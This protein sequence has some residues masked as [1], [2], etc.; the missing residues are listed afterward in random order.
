MLKGVAA[1]PGIAIGKVFLY[2]KEKAEI[3]M[4]NIDESKV[5]YEIERFKK[6]LEVT[7][8]QIQKIKE[9]ALKEFGRDKA[10]IFEAHL[11][12]A[13]DPELVENVE[14]MI[15]TE[16]I[17]ADN[18]VNKV[19]EQNASVMESL[20]DEYLKERA[21]DLRDVGS[22]IINNLLGVKNTSLSELDEQVI[23]IAKDLTPSDTATMKKEMVL[24]FATDIGGRTSHTAIMA[25]SLEIPAVVG[26]GNVT[27]QVNNGNTVIV[28]GLEGVVIVN[29]DENTMNEYK[30]KKENYDKKVEKLK[31]LKDLPAITLDGKKVMLAANIGTPKD[32][33]SALANGAEGV[34]LFRTEFLY[35]DRTTLPTEEEQFEAYKEVAE[36]MEGKPVTIRTLDIGGDKGLPYL[37]MPKEMNPFLGYRAIRLCLDRTD[38]FKTQLR[39]IL[40]ASAYGN[41]HIMYPMISSITDVRRANAVLNEV[42][43]ELD[44]EGIKYDKN[45]K[46]GIMVEIPSAAVT[47]DILAKEV[48]FFSIGTNDL[49][50]YTL[51]VDRMNEHVKDYYQPFNP[52]VLRLI[53]FV[54]DAAHKEGKFAAMCGEMAGD[55]LAT[56]ILLGLGLDEFSM[57]A[58]SIPKV[59]NIIRNIEYEKAKEIAEKVL[60]MKEAEKIQQM[61]EDMIKNID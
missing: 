24:G 17:T 1:S 3:D 51:A 53:K 49:T 10:E 16:L 39:A 41:I 26:L 50:Q 45:I 19:I 36:R 22:R 25:R 4:Q 61:M 14:N 59:K 42:K 35:M 20:D 23:I 33:K 27:T 13:N 58:T 15:K 43:A 21:A 44:K 56:V 47:A 52:A 8:Q 57:S 7:K 55:P 30:T 60:N 31:K 29:P 37:D 11:M 54:I 2:I 28:D 48:D 38:I 34:G 46:V 40:R 32:V 9:E 18:A 5:E 12:L 6:A